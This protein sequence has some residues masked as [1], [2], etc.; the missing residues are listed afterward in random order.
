MV[1]SKQVDALQRRCACGDDRHVWLPVYDGRKPV[2]DDAMISLGNLFARGHT[3]P[4]SDTTAGPTGRSRGPL[5]TSRLV[6]VNCGPSTGAEAR[7]FFTSVQERDSRSGGECPM[8][9]NKAAS[10]LWPLPKATGTSKLSQHRD[11]G[12]L[13]NWRLHSRRLHEPA[14]DL[15]C[16]RPLTAP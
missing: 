1:A 4:E 2:P 9:S 11:D 5:L 8:L 3:S 7:P 6:K 14:D 10:G 12:L 15:A 16:R 13:R